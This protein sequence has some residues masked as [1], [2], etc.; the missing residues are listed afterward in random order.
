MIVDPHTSVTNGLLTQPQL[1]TPEQYLHAG[2]PTDVTLKVRAKEI[3]AVHVTAKTGIHKIGFD[4]DMNNRL[5]AVAIKEIPF[6]GH[7][8][9]GWSLDAN[10]TYVVVADVQAGLTPDAAALLF[11]LPEVVQ[12]GI[13]FTSPLMTRRGTG[14]WLSFALRTSGSVDIAQ[15]AFLAEALTVSIPP[16][17]VF[18]EIPSASDR[19]LAPSGTYV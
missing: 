8:Y 7:H 17:K 1:Q 19:R 15:D 16:K 2:Y 13:T 12:S 11:P 3:Y 4:D 14:N 10:T 18:R 9:A 6:G 5:K